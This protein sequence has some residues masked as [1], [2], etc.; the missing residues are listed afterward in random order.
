M[1]STVPTI[2]TSG[3]AYTHCLQ[4]IMVLNISS[5]CKKCAIFVLVNLFRLLHISCRD[6]SVGRAS[7][8]RSEGPWFKS[9]ELTRALN[10][11]GSRQCPF[12]FLFFLV[13]IVAF[14]CEYIRSAFRSNFLF[15]AFVP[16]SHCRNYKRYL[17]QD[18]RLLLTKQSTKKIK[19]DRPFPCYAPS[20]CIKSRL[21]VKMTHDQEPIT[22][23]NLKRCPILG[24]MGSVIAP[25]FCLFATQTVPL[26]FRLVFATGSPI[27]MVV[28]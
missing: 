12:Y 22:I 4:E 11:P 3:R 20:L 21:S 18:R 24:R 1:E 28:N 26:I 16:Y 2:S 14:A 6:S 19:Y 15:V 9:G 25:P 13:V 23:N 17:Q 8:W 10:K 7:D 5:S 27:I